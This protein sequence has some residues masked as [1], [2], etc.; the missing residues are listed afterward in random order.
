LSLGI[1]SA[2]MLCLEWWAFEVMTLLAGYIGVDEMAAQV[3]IMN[4]LAL[5]F[6]I[7]VGLLQAATCLI[8]Q[9]IGN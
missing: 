4:V 2:M 9:Q 5:V 6:M 7:A 3:I 8:G 1:P